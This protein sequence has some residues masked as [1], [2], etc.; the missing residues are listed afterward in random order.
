MSGSVKTIAVVQVR[1]AECIQWSVIT[2][3]KERNL[4]FSTTWMNL[5][6]II[7][8]KISQTHKE[9]RCMILLMV[10]KPVKYIEAET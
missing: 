8:S 10:S 4:P 9:K 3:K 1:D 7:L 5:E 2:L 6:G